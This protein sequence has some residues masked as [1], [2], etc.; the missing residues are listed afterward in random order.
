M[1]PKLP[2]I[3]LEDRFFER[4]KLVKIL[5][6][7]M[8]LT[9]FQKVITNRFH[10]RNSLM[11][12]ASHCFNCIVKNNYFKW[13][14]LLISWVIWII[15]CF[16]FVPVFGTFSDNFFLPTA[17]WSCGSI[18]VFYLTWKIFTKLSDKVFDENCTWNYF[19]L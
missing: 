17:I 16:W 12:F 7:W 15:S 9:Y 4:Q 10:S 13:N 1:V 11:K 5:V 8:T 14:H 6:T 2:H 3:N 18:L 19:C